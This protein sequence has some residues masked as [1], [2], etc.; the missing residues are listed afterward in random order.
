[1]QTIRKAVIP[2]AGLGTRFYPICKSIPKDMLPIIDK[3]IIQ[4][5][6]EEAVG[7]GIEEIVFVINPSKEMTR[8]YFK[9]DHVLKDQLA[10]KNKTKCLEHLKEIESKATYHFVYQTLPLGDGHAISMAEDIIGEEPFAIL[11]GDDIIRSETY[12]LKQLIDVAQAKNAS[13]I[14]LQDVPLND[15]SSYG[16]VDGQTEGRLTKINHFVEKPDPKSTPSTLGIVGKYV[17][18]DKFWQYLENSRPISKD[19]EWRLIDVLYAMVEHEPVYGL[20]FEGERYDTG[21]KLGYMKAQ[22]VFGLN[23]PEIK[24]ELKQYLRTHVL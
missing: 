17:V 15:V 3:P 6:V 10:S 12:C 4:Y 13:V 14:A 23:D 1:M 24:D 9:P 7:S 5:I 18:T 11:F 16:I 19:G 2:I 21:H 22:I 8:H 20:Q